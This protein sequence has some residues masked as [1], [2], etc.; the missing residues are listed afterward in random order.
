MKDYLIALAHCIY[1]AW[2]IAL[3]GLRVLIFGQP[4]GLSAEPEPEPTVPEPVSSPLYTHEPYPHVPQHPLEV[5]DRK[6][7][8]RAARSRIHAFNE[9]L[10]VWITEH[11]GTMGCAYLFFG[12]GMGSLIGFLTGNVVLAS[13]FGAVS[14]YVLQLVLLPVLQLGTS[15]QGQKQEV[16]IDQSHKNTV[17]LLHEQ[18]QVTKHLSAQDEELLALQKHLAEQDERI[19][20]I[21]SH[22]ENLTAGLAPQPVKRSRKKVVEAEPVD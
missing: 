10:A 13:V 7:Q 2:R 4:H 19:L 21:L 15:I 3:H 22:V 14:S 18:T 5:Y 1:L 17:R 8:A 16:A 6:R 12:I 20:A 11:T 9:W